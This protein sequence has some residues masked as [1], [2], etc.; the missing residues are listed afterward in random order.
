CLEAHR[1]LPLSRMAL[2]PCSV[3][4]EDRTGIHKPVTRSI[5]PRLARIACAVL[6]SHG[7]RERPVHR[8]GPAG[9]RTLLA[10][11]SAL[12]WRSGVAK[13]Y[14]CTVPASRVL[15]LDD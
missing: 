5:S 1:A 3:R 13:G 8:P 12:D 7:A 4:A 15:V 14:R 9:R 2:P 10:W 6:R 11:R